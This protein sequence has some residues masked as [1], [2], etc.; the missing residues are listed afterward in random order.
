MT[1]QP[2]AF[3]IFLAFYSTA[4]SNFANFTY[5]HPPVFFL[6]H[7]M[8]LGF[9]IYGTWPPLLGGQVDEST[10]LQPAGYG[11]VWYDMGKL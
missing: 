11:R 7:W 1:I 9:F 3:G 8:T 10:L 2:L 5:L 6:D 4:I